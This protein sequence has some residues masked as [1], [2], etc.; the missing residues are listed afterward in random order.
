MKK[1]R[2][3]GKK[4]AKKKTAKK[5]IPKT[6][7]ETTEQK[8]EEQ[9]TEEQKTTE[10]SAPEV[11]AP[12]DFVEVRK[13]IANLVGSSASDIAKRAIE[14]AKNGELAQ[15]KYWFEAVGLYPATEETLSKPEDSPAY[16]LLRR[17]LLPANPVTGEEDRSPASSASD[18]KAKGV[19]SADA[20]GAAE[21]NGEGQGVDA[22]EGKD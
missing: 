7:Q 4:T 10:M 11:K 12:L 19:G 9:K 16:A 20:E 13:N 8:T 18:V 5:N 1:A 3:K 6:E 21:R 15:I 22:S 14:G 17:M 2:D